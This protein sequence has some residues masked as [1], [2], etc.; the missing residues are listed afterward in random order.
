MIAE[1]ITSLLV[2]AV[3]IV[4]FILSL[5][6]PTLSSDPAGP[7]FFPRIFSILAGIPALILIKRLISK[8]RLVS[9]S[10]S[11]FIKDFLNAWHRHG[12]DDAEQVRRMTFVFVSAFL[13]PWFITRIGFLIATALYSFA[14]MKILKAETLKS[15]LFS[16]LLALFLYFGFFYFLDAYIAPGTWLDIRF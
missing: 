2:L 11:Y 6:F 13:Y 9:R 7:A 16:T 12:G 10:P 15:A 14:L 8:R 5:N 1:W 4:F 3:S